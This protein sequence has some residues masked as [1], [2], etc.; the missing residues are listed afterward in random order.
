[1]LWCFVWQSGCKENP[2]KYYKKKEKIAAHALLFSISKSAFVSSLL[3]SLPPSSHFYSSQHVESG[4]EKNTTS[5][6][7]NFN[8]HV[9]ADL[10]RFS[11]EIVK[12]NIF[13]IQC[14]CKQNFL[15][16]IK[17][18]KDKP[19]LKDFIF[20]RIFAPFTRIFT[21]GG[22]KTSYTL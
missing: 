12:E 1:M 20:I 19:V 14:P 4:G 17:S 6:V 22:T 13:Y 5:H 10:S 21:P 16:R 8:L 18:E 15:F 7:Y 3:K 11:K 2:K 9:H